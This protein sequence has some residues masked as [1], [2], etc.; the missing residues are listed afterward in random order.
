VRPTGILIGLQLHPG[1]AGAERR[2]RAAV[3]SLLR[4][5]D[6]GA[7]NLQFQAGARQEHAGIATLAE[8][9]ED[10]TTVTG[11]SDRRKPI[12]REM[13]DVLAR[14]A[15]GRGLRYFGFINADIVVTP[16]VL[17]TVGRFGCD[18]YAISRHDVESF[19]QPDAAGSVLTPGVDMFV[20]S[21]EWWR[22]QCTRFRPYIVGETLW[23]NVFTAVMMCHSNGVVLNREPLI[24]HERHEVSRLEPTPATRHNGFLAALDAR[25]FSM[26]C[27]YWD[28][29]ERVRAAR[30]GESDAAAEEVLRRDAFV[31]RRSPADAVRQTIRAVRAR[32]GY[33]RLR[34]AWPPAAATRS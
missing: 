3:E 2:Q 26:W 25:Y 14:E 19:D 10:A 29:L 23:D 8:L 27:E 15:A 16:A 28:A 33:R 1:D 13:F 30:H 20:V 4:L 22:R 21:C 5:E 9:R 7:V 11:T 12:A 31:W 34:A 32:A 6:I 18:T 24:L 17:E